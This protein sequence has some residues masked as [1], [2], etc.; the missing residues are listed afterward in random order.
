MNKLVE[1][2]LNT[3]L[4]P[5]SSTLQRH[6]EIKRGDWR[7]WIGQRSG[8]ERGEFCQGCENFAINRLYT[9]AV[10]ADVVKLGLWAGIGYTIYKLIS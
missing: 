5:G 4:V 2:I 1:K 7:Y 9:L 6:Q 10:A 3:S 8:A